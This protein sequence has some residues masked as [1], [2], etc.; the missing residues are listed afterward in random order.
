MSRGFI[1]GCERELLHLSGAIQPYGVLLKV[2]RS[3]YVTHASANV[4]E[5]I[6]IDA[7]DVI[8]VHADSLKLPHGAPVQPTDRRARRQTV[9][10]RGITLSVLA[11]AAADG[12]MLLEMIPQAVRSAD[13]TES[14]VQRAYPPSSE[15]EMKAANQRL[16]AEISERTGYARTMYYQFHDDGHGEVIAEAR[17]GTAFGSYQGLHFPASDIPKI[18]RALYLQNPWRMIPD[19]TA[20]PVA[21]LTRSAESVDL[22]RSDLRSVSEVHRAYLANMGVGS[23]LSF[24]VAAGDALDAL[25][26]CHHAGPREPDVVLLDE[27]AALVDA[28]ALAA[29]SF[30][31]GQRMRLIDG[32]GRR[33]S[34][35]EALVATTA[36][37][38]DVWPVLGPRMMADFGADGALMCVGD[39]AYAVGHCLDDDTLNR[40]EQVSF[41]RGAVVW[42]SDSL[43]RDVEDLMLTPVA[44]AAGVAIETSA[45]QRVR[46]WVSRVEHIDEV[47]WGGNPDKPVESDSVDKAISPRRSFEAWVERR[48]GYSRPWTTETELLLRHLRVALRPLAEKAWR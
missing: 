20:D 45:R 1:D 17:N 31:A 28:H 41:D 8:G 4:Y 6:G 34:D 2:D 26:S 40:I 33:F 36:R 32:M 27:I 11:I 43:T 30:R 42:Q 3:G 16:V 24:P 19:A 5:V 47:T 10:H 46:L 29:S 7:G 35:I 22:T 39:T 23:A 18:A 14:V 13:D 12:G 21:L 48:I 15:A 44:G 37:M 38:D 9:T 25:I